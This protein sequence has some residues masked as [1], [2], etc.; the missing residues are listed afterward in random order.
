MRALTSSA[1]LDAWEQAQGHGPTVRTL[2]LL[3][4]AGPQTDWEELSALPLSE[5]DRRL[6]EL[7]EGTL[8]VRLEAVARCPGCGEPL[9]VE[10]DTRELRAGAETGAAE[11]ALSREG[12]EMRFRLLNSLDLLAA[13]RCGGVGEARRRLAER[14][15]LAARREGVPVA[16][17]EL[18]EEDVAALAEALAAADPGAELLL[19][20]RCPAC[21]NGWWEILDV[22]SFVW[23]EMEVQARQLLREVHALA[24]AYGWR[25]ADVLALSPRR[26]RLYLE[27]VGA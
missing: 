19:E 26:R 5:R 1:L 23:A 13:E 3:A 14:C 7:R 11:G 21:G 12:L 25:E 18:A 20:L 10:L 8:G 24:R 2:A 15:L 9:D 17:A 22:A 4:A 6:L 27:M 16:A